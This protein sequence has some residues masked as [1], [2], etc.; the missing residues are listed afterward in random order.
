LAEDNVRT[1]NGGPFGAVVVSAGAILAEA[2]NLVTASN[3][4]TAHAEVV[5]I[6]RACGLLGAFQLSGCELYCSCE[7]CP[8]CLGAIYWAR[9]SAVYFAATHLDA[10]SAGFDDSLIYEELRRHPG[11][12]RIPMHHVTVEGAVAPFEHWRAALRRVPY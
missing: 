12:R 11:E 8:M 6:R 3:D 2:V 7:P 5:A 9:P 10:A 4:P 1:G